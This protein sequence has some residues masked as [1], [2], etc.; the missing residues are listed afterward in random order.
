[1]NE[2][3]NWAVYPKNFALKFDPLLCDKI[4]VGN[5]TIAIKE[6]CYKSYFNQNGKNG[7]MVYGYIMPRLNF[8]VDA[9]HLYQDL[10]NGII[11]N[12]IQYINNFKGNFILI[13]YFDD[14]IY[15][16]ND[17]FGV[18]K[19]FYFHSPNTFIA[20]DNINFIK[21]NIQLNLSQ[22][23]ILKYFIFNYFVNGSTIYNECH[24]S[25][26]AQYYKIGNT[27]NNDKYFSIQQFIDDRKVTFTK[28]ESINHAVNLWKKIINQYKDFFADSQ[29][30]QTLTAGMD[31][32]MILAGF[33][34]NNFNPITFTFGRFDSLDVV[35][36]KKI[37][38][39]LQLKHRHFFPEG[40]FF[41]NYGPIAKKVNTL[42]SGMASIYR[43]H[44]LE[45]YEKMQQKDAALFF[46][47]I[48]SEI[49][50]GLYPDGLTVP[51]I[52][53]DYWLHGNIEIKNYFPNSW[54]TL[55]DSELES[56]T[57]E[58]RNYDFVNRPDLFLFRVMIPLHFG[59]DIKLCESLNMN[60][61]APFWDI[62]FLEFQRSTPFFTDNNR[63]E[64]FAKLGHYQRRK[65]PYFSANVISALDKENARLSLGKGYS[66]LDYKRSLYYASLRFLF[67]KTFYK[68][69]YIVPNFNYGNWFKEYLKTFFNKNEIK[70][71]NIEKQALLND[72]SNEKGT[73]EVSFLNYTKLINIYY[74]HYE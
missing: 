44:R 6:K 27:I 7:I 63:K 57:N 16:C 11:N 74:T 64:E 55:N 37:A 46:G 21:H 1:M 29:V 58:I 59:Q 25:T 72:I 13:V 42:S 47:F 33:R 51:K 36:A 30:S 50:R 22:Q 53:T 23:N 26:E 24:Y 45:A 41:I 61:I 15:I 71:L 8:N 65:G 18:D 68:K 52:V 12:G 9:N 60:A 73:E 70:F 40:D 54:F 3:I 67:Y 35:H 17:Q 19:F 34:A 38:E 28:K 31:S 49:I 4:N 14:I 32:R 69:R 48:G 66:P 10:L 62:D 39:A 56:I 20:T 5:Y 2:I 43:A